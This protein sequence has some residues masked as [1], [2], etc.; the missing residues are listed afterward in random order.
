MRLLALP[1]LKIIQDALRLSLSKRL[2]Q[3]GKSA[4][5]KTIT[6]AKPT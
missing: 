6:E 1:R 5:N 2:E 4:V 3:I